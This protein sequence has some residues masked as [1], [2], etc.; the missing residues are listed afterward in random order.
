MENLSTHLSGVEIGIPQT[1]K[2]L[3]VYPLTATAHTYDLDY[4]LF[5]KNAE[6][7]KFDITEIL[8][9]HVSNL[10]VKNADARRYLILDGD[11]LQAKEDAYISK[12]SAMIPAKQA[13]KLPV[14]DLMN[15]RWNH[16]SDTFHASER[17]DVAEGKTMAI[18]KPYVRTSKDDPDARKMKV[19]ILKEPDQQDTATVDTEDEIF[20]KNRTRPQEYLKN[21]TVLPSQIGAVFVINSEVAGV[22]IFENERIFRENLPNLVDC[23]TSEPIR[24]RSNFKKRKADTEVTELWSEIQESTVR[25]C[26]TPGE[27]EDLRFVDGDVIGGALIVKGRIVH[28]SALPKE[29][30]VNTP[31][32]RGRRQRALARTS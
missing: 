18:R 23:Y 2:N 19:K 1:F 25:E 29:R 28:L 11:S 24:I 30:L 13:I 14:F 5:R 22:D 15:G 20:V 31:E 8:N 26:P 3:T 9:S 4:S 10:E 7:N 16:E 17:Y 27:G 32:Y 12:V 21:I 6:H